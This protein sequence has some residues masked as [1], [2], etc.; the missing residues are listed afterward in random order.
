MQD[1]DWGKPQGLPLPPEKTYQ[2]YAPSVSGFVIG[3]VAGVDSPKKRELAWAYGAVG[4]VGVWASG[5]N[6]IYDY[7]SHGT[8]Y[9]ANV[10]HSF[11]LPV[12]A[13]S[14]FV[15]WWKYASHNDSKPDVRFSW[16]PATPAEGPIEK[17]DA[18]AL[19]EIPS[20]DSASPRNVM[21]ETG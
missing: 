18:Q 5:G 1:I 8:K 16:M 6:F 19:A 9:W 21:E 11:T 7:T 14:T 20:D 4:P 12:P 13:Q 3:R 17:I 10:D 15:I 2:Y